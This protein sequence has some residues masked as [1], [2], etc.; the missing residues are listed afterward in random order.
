MLNRLYF[1]LFLSLILASCSPGSLAD[2][3]HEGEALSRNLILDLDKIE[4]REQLLRAEPQLK[5]HFNALISLMIAARTF[6]EEH[7]EDLLIDLDRP[8]EIEIALQ[9]QLKRIYA[10]EGGREVIESAQQEAIIRLDAFERSLAKKKE[11]L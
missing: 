3:Q 10:I 9:E 11:R 4:D 7:P 8:K 5:K 1:S 2:F 6:Q